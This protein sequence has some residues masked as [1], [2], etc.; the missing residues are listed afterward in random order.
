MEGHLAS[1]EVRGVGYYRDMK[2][3]CAKGRLR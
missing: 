1:D 2:E 3:P